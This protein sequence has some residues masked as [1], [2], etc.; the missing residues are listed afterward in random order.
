MQRRVTPPWDKETKARRGRGSY[1]TPNVATTHRK[2]EVIS[3]IGRT[4]V[5]VRIDKTNSR[6][7]KDHGA[8]SDYDE[9]DLEG[10]LTA[11]AA[12]KAENQKASENCRFKEEEDMITFD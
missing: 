1:K 3:G 4:V 11:M 10:M 8:S 7:D 6:Q 9:P 12:S 5:S 2:T